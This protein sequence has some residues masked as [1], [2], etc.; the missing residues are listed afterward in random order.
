MSIS[1]QLHSLPDSFVHGDSPGKNIG[2]GGHALLPGI[3]PTQG[4][5]PGLPHCQ[6][7]LYTSILLVGNF[8]STNTK[9]KAILLCFNRTRFIWKCFIF[10]V[11]HLWD[12]LSKEKSWPTTLKGYLSGT[13]DHTCYLSV[14]SHFSHVRLFV[15]P[16]TV[17]RQ[18]PLSMGFSRQEYCSGLPC[19]PQGIFLTQE[20]NPCLSHLLYWQAVLYHAHHLGS[21]HLLA[22][23]MQ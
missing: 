8:N 17:A 1:L 23:A 22:G 7:I 18:A 11:W 19:P 5:N 6:W 13:C 15:T 9:R 2:V 12:D 16:W 14:Q 20:S 10:I 3:F 21:P 4:L